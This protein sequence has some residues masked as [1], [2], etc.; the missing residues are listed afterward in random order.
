MEEQEYWF[1]DKE[2]QRQQKDFSDGNMEVAVPVMR[3]KR[4]TELY[5]TKKDF[6]DKQEQIVRRGH[7]EPLIVHFTDSGIKWVSFL[8]YKE[9][10]DGNN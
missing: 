2:S 6:I 9:T 1:E 4:T 10:L 8:A 5:M 3:S 7:R